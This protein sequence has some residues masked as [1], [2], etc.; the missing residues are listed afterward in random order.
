MLSNSKWASHILPDDI[1]NW[2]IIPTFYWCEME[3]PYQT[4]MN[5]KTGI[6]TQWITVGKKSNCWVWTSHWAH[7]SCLDSLQSVSKYISQ[8]LYKN[9]KRWTSSIQIVFRAG[10][11]LALVQL[12]DPS[13]LLRLYASVKWFD[14]KRSS[15]D[16]RRLQGSAR[17]NHEH[18]K[19]VL[20][21]AVANQSCS[22]NISKKAFQSS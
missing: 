14:T 5:F 12:T 15:R 9:L 10:L 6:K 22:M 17:I 3:K 18:L 1:S 11:N 7:I 19:N 20:T 4:G 16:L 2:W 8:T 13:R 21:L